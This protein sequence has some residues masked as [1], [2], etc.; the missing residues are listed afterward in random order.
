MNWVNKIRKG[1]TFLASGTL[2]C[3][4]EKIKNDIAICEV[5]NGYWQ[6]AFDLKTG[7]VVEEGTDRQALPHCLAFKILIEGPFEGLDYNEKIDAAKNKYDALQMK[8]Y[9]SSMNIDESSIEIA[10]IAYCHMQ[11]GQEGI[12]EWRYCETSCESCK[13]STKTAIEA[14]ENN[15]V[16]ETI[17]RYA[18]FAGYNYY[19]SG[20]WDDLYA[21]YDTIE[22][23][24]RI[25]S[26]LLTREADGY[27]RD[28]AYVI[29][30]L[31]G[32]RQ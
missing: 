30:L 27:A 13:Q 24:K 32:N 11:C 18:V 7:Y 22:E 1:D 6:I 23:A 15:K 16:S 4:V 26:L 20:G 25:A 31:G 8:E 19:P 9:E 17:L 28:W 2:L 10:A 5:E 21:R 12:S 14:Y 29:D 3:V